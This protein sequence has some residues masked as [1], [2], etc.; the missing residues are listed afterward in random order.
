LGDA[1]QGA[2]DVAVL[3]EAAEKRTSGKVGDGPIL[4][5]KSFEVTGE[6]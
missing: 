2:L 1:H 3:P 4:L 5:Q 6:Q